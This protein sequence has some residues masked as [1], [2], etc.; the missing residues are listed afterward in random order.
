MSGQEDS[1]RSRGCTFF[2]IVE[3][4]VANA[5][6]ITQIHKA[7]PIDLP[8]TCYGE[9]SETSFEKDSNFQKIRFPE[10]V[11][12]KIGFFLIKQFVKSSPKFD[13][14]KF[15]ILSYLYFLHSIRT[16]FLSTRS[17]E[18]QFH[19]HRIFSDFIGKPLRK[20]PRIACDAEWASVTH[21]LEPQQPPLSPSPTAAKVV[22]AKKIDSGE[23][24]SVATSISSDRDRSHIAPDLAEL[25]SDSYDTVSTHS[26]EDATYQ[27]EIEDVDD[28]GDDNAPDNDKGDDA[29]AGDLLPSSAT[30]SREK[31]ENPDSVSE[32]S[33]GMSPKPQQ[34]DDAVKSPTQPHAQRMAEQP[35]TSSERPLLAEN[36]SSQLPSDDDAKSPSPREATRT[37]YDTGKSSSS[38]AKE[39]VEL[40][41]SSEA[42]LLR[43]SEPY[44]LMIELSAE[45]LNKIR[46]HLVD[47]PSNIHLFDELTVAIS[48]SLM[49][50]MTAFLNQSIEYKKFVQLKSYAQRNVTYE[51]FEMFRVL[52]KG[53]FGSVFM[54]K[55]NDTE[56]VYA[57]KE[58]KKKQIKLKKSHRTCEAEKAALR[59]MNSPFVINMKY[60]FTNE[61]S[62]FIIMDI[63]TGGDLRFHLHQ[64]EARCFDEA[65]ARF[66]AAEMI[67]GMEHMHSHKLLYRDLKPNNVLLDKEGHIRLSDFG[68]VMQLPQKSSKWNLAGTPGYW[69]PECYQRKEQSYASD[70][71]SWAVMV[72]EM[73][74]GK[75]PRCHCKK[76]SDQWCTF[77]DSEQMR[78]N[79]KENGPFELKITYADDYFSKSCADLLSR[80]LVFDPKQRLGY[81]GAVDLKNHPFFETINWGKLAAREIL[82]PFRPS[83]R[84]VHAQT[85]AEIGDVDQKRYRKVTITERDEQQYERWNY[86]SLRAAE[87]ELVQVLERNE[88]ARNLP[89]VPEAKPSDKCCCFL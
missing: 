31:H 25:K 63:C 9:I 66:Y 73:I 44:R 16:K 23:P 55:K 1:K 85:L 7:T 84:D 35:A 47:D 81:N 62:L 22:S 71:W 42:P 65:R 18:R 70:W 49:P 82:P 76:G 30:Q 50:V 77:S 69:S 89:P 56:A 12:D 59:K 68:L 60:A 4:T 48:A 17:L 51:D 45:L 32:L 8:L 40:K 87:D 38:L 20:T 58:M 15:E 53:A 21:R 24:E 11:R 41:E 28:A 2:D 14:H 46:Q 29:E 54:V 52:G 78:K 19:S 5:A 33:D 26:F 6:Y 80:I 83:D 34:D 74:R 64:L 3:T 13:A 75:K 27:D 86:F 79:S 37:L 88:R 43:K 36:S 57:M 72:Y 61:H 39:D 67:L 10:F